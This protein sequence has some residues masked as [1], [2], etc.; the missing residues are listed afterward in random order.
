[1]GGSAEVRRPRLA[2][3]ALGCRVSQ[4][5]V[6]A[7]AEAS[8]AAFE[9]VPAGGAAD[10][11]VVNTC[12]LTADAE[13]AARRAIRRAVRARPG[14]RVIA[15]GCAAQ[16]RPADLG[17]IGGVAAVVGARDAAALPA[18]LAR[19]AG[20]AAPAPPRAAPT[21]ALARARRPVKVQDG[22]DA[23]CAYCVVPSVRGPSRS[24][25]LEDAVAAIR[26]AAA[27]HREVV[28]TGVHLGAWGRDL[29][30]RRSLAD[31][32][33]AAAAAGVPARLRL[34]SLEPNEVPLDVLDDP[35]VRPVLCAH[36]HLPVQ[37]G[38]ARVLAAMGRPYGPDLVRRVFGEAAARLPGACLGADVLCGFPGETDE[39]HRAT[40]AL[41]E[42]LPL[43]YLHVFAFSPRPGTRAATLPDPVPPRVARERAAE[44]RALSDRRWRAF[45]AGRVGATLE[46]VVERVAGGVARGTSRE[47][48]PVRWPAR[49]EARGDLARV[50]VAGADAGGC[51]GE[52]AGPGAR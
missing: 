8:A 50:R 37:S 13:A 39:D 20:S 38:S 36:L 15:A 52:A 23:S 24:V 4:A 7:L 45:L 26:A 22:C 17:A 25:P 9:I 34:S 33:R 48:V 47:W 6:D 12:A 27:S 3:L 19:L 2:L 14:L 41:V 28:L 35:G 31:L 32:V 46:V 5:E 40:L 42:A 16:A 49:G 11:L 21:G 1:V 51:A 43:A 29:S 30:P 18:V 44:L 10:V